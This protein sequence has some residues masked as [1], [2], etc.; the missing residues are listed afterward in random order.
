MS[1][2]RAQSVVDYL[3]KGGIESERLTAKGYGKTQPVTADKSMEK[4]YD[5]IKENNTLDDE[6][7]DKLTPEQQEI[8]NRINRLTTFRGLKTTYR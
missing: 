4:K 3:I 7:I 1:V 8:A 2:R 5:F 6:F